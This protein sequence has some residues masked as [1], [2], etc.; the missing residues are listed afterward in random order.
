MKT[1]NT[2]LVSI[3]CL[4]YN[5]ENYIQQ[6]FD[7]FLS[8]N[9]N[10]DFEIIIH[11]DASTDNS[12]SII[13]DYV[14]KDDRFKPIYQTDNKFSKGERIWFKYLF[15]KCKGKYI[16]ICD[17]DDYWTDPLKLQKQVDFLEN[18]SDYSIV[19]AKFNCFY[20]Q[21]GVMSDWEHEKNKIPNANIKNLIDGNFIFAS[22]SL[23]INDFKIEPWWQDF[24]IGDWP[25]FI[26]QIKNRKIKILDEFMGVYRVHNKGVFS[27]AS[28]IQQLNTELKCLTTLYKN[29]SFTLDINNHLK[30]RISD[31][32]RKI[33]K[34]KI[35]NFFKK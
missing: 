9:T 32:K 11:D 35:K 1:N 10:F 13:S 27:K 26:L 22:S 29:S 14:K 19:G 8:Q 4:V 7:S 17:G 28:I 31:K 2:P 20:Q 15:P 34:L 3:C 33:I 24:P 21:T 23:F 5:Q 25:F 12:K 18:N 16:A 6:T 30:K